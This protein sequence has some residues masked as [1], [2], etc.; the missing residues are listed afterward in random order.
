MMMKSRKARRAERIG[1]N[2][3]TYKILV[4]E[5]EGKYLS[6]NLDSAGRIIIL[7]WILKVGGVGSDS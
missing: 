6:E 3:N 1:E 4:E 2:K 7:K 5:A